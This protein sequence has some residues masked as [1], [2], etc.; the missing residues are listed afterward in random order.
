MNS[1]YY[2]LP[3]VMTHFGAQADLLAGL[4]TGVAELVRVVQGNLI[5]VF[6]AERYGRK[7]S[8]EEKFTLNVREAER[9]LAV[10]RQ[11]NPAPLVEPRPLEQRQVGNCRDFSVLLCALL[12]HQG[13]PA[14]ARCGFG[15]YFLPGHYEDHWMCEV[16]HAG[17]GRWVR[18]DAQIDALQ[19]KELRLDFDP[20]DMPPGKF[21][22]AGDAYQMCR[23]GQADPEKFGIF[24]MHGLDFIQGNVVREF[25]ALNKV[26]ILPWDWGWGFLTPGPIGDLAL[27]DRLSALTLHADESFD[28][29]RAIFEADPAL[30]VP[31]SAQPGG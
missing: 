21:V 18:V 19:R 14:R 6:W 2:A 23:A 16:W 1:E 31:V 5:H 22:L 8:E 12:R 11:V 25:L 29:L 27:F 9:K 24:D 10:M 17:E 28:E 7:L 26:E 13:I 15:T 3:G 4:P 20:L 30:G